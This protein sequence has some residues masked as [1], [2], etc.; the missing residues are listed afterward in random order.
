MTYKFIE[1][2]KSQTPKFINFQ[3]KELGKYEGFQTH[4]KYNS[5][6]FKTIV[7]EDNEI[8]KKYKSLYSEVIFK[9]ELQNLKFTTSKNNCEPIKFEM[10]EILN[11]KVTVNGFEKKNITLERLDDLVKGKGKKEIFIKPTLIYY[12]ETEF[13]IKYKLLKIIITEHKEE[14]YSKYF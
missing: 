14:D 10:F 6:T 7:P 9:K 3:L 13:R 1:L 8:I 2:K 11:I 4:S 12:N 5:R